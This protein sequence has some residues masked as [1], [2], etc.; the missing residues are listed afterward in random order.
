MTFCVCLDALTAGRPVAEALRVAAAAGAVEF[1]DW[2]ARD[3]DTL[4]AQARALGLRVAVFSG[5]TFDEPLV[6]ARGH[7]RALAHLARSLE[8]ARRLGTRLLVIHVGYAQPGRPRAAQWADAVRGVRA[9]GALAQAAGVTLALE[10][11]NSAVDHPGYFLDSLPAALAMLR[12][13]DHPSVRLLLDVYHMRVMHA[14]LLD[15]LPEALA[16]TAHLHVADVPGRREPGTGA[17]PW[18]AV[19]GAVRA[20]RYPGAVG[21]ECWPSGDPAAALRRALEVLSR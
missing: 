13:V 11:L 20:S 5:T 7:P 3:V 4:A 10:P 18:A 19:M 15:R 9:A 2:R 14:D 16:V 8:V 12:E 17:M 6:D 21:L 1:W